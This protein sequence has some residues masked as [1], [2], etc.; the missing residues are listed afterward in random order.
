MNRPSVGGLAH[1]FAVGILTEAAPSFR[2]F[3]E[4]VGGVVGHIMTDTVWLQ[5]THR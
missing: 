2:A 4:R 1:P 5:T 3:C